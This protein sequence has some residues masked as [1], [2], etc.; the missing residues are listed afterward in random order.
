MEHAQPMVS[1]LSFV[2]VQSAVERVSDQKGQYPHLSGG[3]GSSQWLN[4]ITIIN[5]R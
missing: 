3:R 1:L 2:S 5:R 4:R